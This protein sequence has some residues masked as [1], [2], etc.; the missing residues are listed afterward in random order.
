MPG[1]YYNII[2]WS[3]FADE[4]GEVYS[5]Y[6][7]QDPISDVNAAG[8]ELVGVV[9]KGEQNISHYLVYPLTDEQQ[10]WYYAVAC[11]DQA[12]N[13]GPAT[14]SSPVVNTAR[15]VATYAIEA[16]A[17]FVVDGDFAEWDAAGIMPVE[18]KKSN[19]FS[20]VSYGTI[21]D[22][23]DMTANIYMAMDDDYLYIGV[24]V[25]EDNFTWAGGDF[26][27]SDA[28][29]YFI[30]LYDFRDA[31]HKSMKRGS[32]PD[33][34]MVFTQ[35]YLRRDPNWFLLG[36]PAV[37]DG[38]YAFED[39]GGGEYAYEARIALDSLQTAD[40]TRFHR[41]NGMRI[42]H[43]ITMHDND[44]G[45]AEG[46]MVTSPK[47]KDSAWHDP[48]VW[49]YTWIGDTTDVAS[50]IGDNNGNVITQF[51]LKQNYP[52]P[53]NPSTTIYY[54]LAKASTVKLE[55]YN[56]LGQKVSTLVN[57]RQLKGAYQVVF[58]GAN[59]TSG[60]YFYKIEAG[61][62]SSVKKMLLVK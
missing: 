54:D 41:K 50:A 25:L 3:D 47:N 32:E 46:K 22:D 62:F 8:V 29:E 51:S 20:Y 5:V 4:S 34:K 59:L 55:V 39:W 7:S 37:A 10:T 40:D 2:A 12:G 53:F 36:D 56:V 27:M 9:V 26:W 33:Y 16:P 60:V 43:E 57:S 61:E 24:S 19:G 44:N 21:T 1:G 58:D 18:L 49:S 13:V 45:V 28:V 14:N 23:A 31:A 42:T 38:D 52:N 35:D 48:Q 15:G 30:G 6:A 17:N 11:K